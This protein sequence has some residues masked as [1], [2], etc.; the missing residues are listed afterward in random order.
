MRRTEAKLRRPGS[1]RKRGTC[2][3]QGGLPA[4]T[5][6]P[7][8]DNEMFSLYCCPLAGRDPNCLE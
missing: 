7:G 4:C 2:T 5:C 3:P 1:L 6:N 8:F